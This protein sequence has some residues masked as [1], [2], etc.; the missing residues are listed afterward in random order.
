[1]FLF[2]SRPRFKG[3]CFFFLVFEANEEHMGTTYQNKAPSKNV[4]VDVSK[5]HSIYPVIKALKG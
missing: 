3:F 4:H 5:C 2:L 1:M